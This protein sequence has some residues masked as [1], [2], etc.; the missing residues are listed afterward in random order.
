MRILFEHYPSLKCGWQHDQDLSAIFAGK[1]KAKAYQ[2]IMEWIQ[3]SQSPNQS[4]WNELEIQTLKQFSSVAKSIKYH[5][6][7]ILNFFDSRS[8]N[9]SAES[10]NAKIKLFRSKLKGVRETTFFCLDY[11]DLLLNPMSIV[12]TRMLQWKL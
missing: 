12:L 7:S 11:P 1:E 4:T 5:L 8:T 3:V 2:Q 9:A 6:E 10:F